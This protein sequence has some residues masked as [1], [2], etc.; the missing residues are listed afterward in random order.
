MFVSLKAE[1]SEWCSGLPF[2]R[3]RTAVGI[4]C[5]DGGMAGGSVNLNL[6]KRHYHESNVGLVF[7]IRAISELVM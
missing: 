2:V 6:R 4:H 5:G 3:Q 7:K 1:K